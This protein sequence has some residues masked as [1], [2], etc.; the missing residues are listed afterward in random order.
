MFILVISKLLLNCGHE[1]SYIVLIY[2]NVKKSGHFCF[3]ALVIMVACTAD[4]L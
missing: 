2:G 4:H 1:L 3:H